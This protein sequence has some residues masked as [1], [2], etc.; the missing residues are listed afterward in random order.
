MNLGGQIL[1]DIV[2][3]L[4]ELYP[5]IEVEHTKNKLSTVLSKY[6]IQKVESSVV[7]PDI[8]DTIHL[9][10]S[11]KRF[12]ALSSI[13]LDNYLLELSMFAD[14]VKK[15][16]EDIATADVRLFLSQD[17]ALKMSTIRKKLS[18]LKSFLLVSF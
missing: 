2:A 11:A 9:F 3:A 18:V 4:I 14:I 16:S 1:L 10:T 7:H 17:G 6:Y 13:S 12:E 5:N 15:K 8:E